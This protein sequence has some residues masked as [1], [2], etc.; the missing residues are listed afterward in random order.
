MPAQDP[1]PSD[2]NRENGPRALRYAV[3]EEASPR[4]PNV[5]TLVSAGLFLYVG[6]GLGVIGISDQPLYNASVDWLVWNARIIGGA[7]LALFVLE[8]TPLR[9][10][11]VA[12]LMISGAATLL[13]VA[14]GG[15]WLMYSD[16][17]GILL[18][19]FGAL[20]ASG[21]YDA[22]LRL[23]PAGSPPNI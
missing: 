11:P 1:P 14:V 7:L 8:L 18:L 10:V 12:R 6:F 13:C 20:N 2:T 19:V 15:I 3:R 5:V 4:R 16:Y 23:A 21:T 9:F 22:W 17:D